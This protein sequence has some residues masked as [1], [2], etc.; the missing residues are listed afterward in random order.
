LAKD[1][2]YTLAIS[3]F[4]GSSKEMAKVLEVDIKNTKRAIR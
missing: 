2:V 3:Q 4:V 1:I